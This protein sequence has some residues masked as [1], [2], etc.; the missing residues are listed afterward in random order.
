MFEIELD[1]FIN[2]Q[3]ELVA[4][5][6]NKVLAIQVDE[7]IGVYDTMLD[8]YLA[9]KDADLLGKVMLQNCIAGKEAYTVTAYYGI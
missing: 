5:Y 3:P 4:K 1:Y 6:N 7:I 8:A 2:N 9:V